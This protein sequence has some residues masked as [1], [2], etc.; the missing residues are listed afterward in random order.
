VCVRDMDP[1][2]LKQYRVL[3]AATSEAAPI[4]VRKRKPAALTGHTKRLKR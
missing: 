2:T 1:E 3:E 4:G